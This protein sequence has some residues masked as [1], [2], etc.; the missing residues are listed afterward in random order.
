MTPASFLIMLGFFAF[1][2][3][4]FVYAGPSVGWKDYR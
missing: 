4:T 2:G 1:V 3:V